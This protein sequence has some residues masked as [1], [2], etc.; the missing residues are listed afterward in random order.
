MKR[1]IKDD[2]YYN[3]QNDR[4][5]GV[6]DNNTIVQELHRIPVIITPETKF[7]D[8]GC[9]SHALTVRY[10][11]TLGAQSYG[12]DIGEKAESA[13]ETYPCRANMKRAD[14]HDGV[15]FDEKFDIISISHT[16]E[17]CHTPELALSHIRAALKDDGYVWGIVPVEHVEAN[18]TPHYCVFHNEQEHID[19]YEKNGFEVV[20]HGIHLTDQRNSQIW[21]RKK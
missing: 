1:R 8:V 7:L 11:H 10:F 19:I 3:L 20:W 14:I 4:S 13:W 2:E 12:I 15:P 5:F 6:L 9:R 16:L 21:A 17:H 18:H